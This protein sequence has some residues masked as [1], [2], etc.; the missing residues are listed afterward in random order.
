MNNIKELIEKIK[1][2]SSSEPLRD[3]KIGVITLALIFCIAY[4]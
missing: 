4:N 2:M 3:Y 1:K